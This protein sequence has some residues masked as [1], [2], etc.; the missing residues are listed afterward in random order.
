MLIGP[1]TCMELET[2]KALLLTQVNFHD[3]CSEV[4]E[5]ITENYSFLKKVH[6]A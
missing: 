1:W 5:R 2:L 6:S 4:Y 3:S